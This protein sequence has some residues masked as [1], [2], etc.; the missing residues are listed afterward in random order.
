MATQADSIR[1]RS[2]ASTGDE[3]TVIVQRAQAFTNASG[4]A[5]A[6]GEGNTDEIICRARSGASAP[7][8]GTPLR[9]EGSFTGIC[10]QSGK[11]LRCDD[12]ETDTRVDTAAIRALGIRSMVVT[13][14][15][16]EGKVVG[17]LA[18]FA[19]TPHAFTITH[20]AVLKT[21]ADQ[22]AAHLQRERRAREE[23]HYEPPAPPA[24]KPVASASVLPAPVVIKSMA[25]SGGNGA[26]AA[27]PARSQTATVP[28][29]E[30][31]RP[32]PVA[33][34]IAPAVPL[35]KKVEKLVEKQPEFKPFDYKPPE[36]KS[37]LAP[38]I[39]PNLSTFDAVA[40]EHR[41]P[42]LNKMILI[43]GIVA[44][45]AVGGA[46]FGFMKMGK[47]SSGKTTQQ[48]AN[49]QPQNPAPAPQPTLTPTANNT[50]TAPVTTASVQPPSTPAPT[51]PE[52]TEN[53]RNENKRAESQRSEEQPSKP[54]TIELSQGNSK[55]SAAASAPQPQ[56]PD[57]APSLAVGASSSDLGSL[58]RPVNAP[59]PA[60][61]AQ[62]NL[63][64]AVLVHTVPAVY[65]EIAK[66]RHLSGTVT[67]KVMIGKDG[68][69]SNPR[70]VSGPVIFRDAAFDAV[71]QWTF[72]PATLNGQAIEQETQ[73][74][75]KFNQ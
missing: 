24:P 46:I 68:K 8:V 32:V 9:V 73:I 49:Q 20:V 62:S 43:G 45:L 21:M 30:P 47:S 42:G 36:V 48:A 26:A 3:L 11:E 71:K 41:K 31:I 55:L 60:M 70:F 64:N 17:V 18:V 40:G 59:K 52:K 53:K 69:V 4:A 34:D 6:V 75:M 35:P 58:I 72:K 74:T 7:D 37:E 27:A 44:V 38:A 33:A 63:V 56:T 25:T 2:R 61:V 13:P 14:I 28:K 16:E 67:L 23:G 51:K 22:I 5:I 54:A 57:V 15:K 50:A 66:S 10:I 29:V 12:A 19:P 39:K 65:P 1:T